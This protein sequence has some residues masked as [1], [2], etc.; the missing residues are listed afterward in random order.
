[1][2]I[3]AIGAHPD[4]IEIGCGGALLRYAAAGHKVFLF[5]L[6]DGSFGGDPSVRRQEQE[7][8]ARAMGAEKVIWGNYVD[9]EIVD[10]RELIIKIEEIIAQVQ[11]DLVFMNYYEDIHQDHRATAKAAISAT[12]YVKEIL[13][14]EVPTTLRFDPDVFVDI[15]ECFEKKQELLSIHGSQVDKTRVDDL[16]ILEISLSCAHFRGFQARVKFAEGFKALRLLRRI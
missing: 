1:M 9:T 4:D 13:F 14:F 10:N 7:R 5:V 3:L 6:S 11:P 8:S 12:R 16:T 2:N 15:R